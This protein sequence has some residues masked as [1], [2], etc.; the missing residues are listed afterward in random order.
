MDDKD[1]A[2]ARK[3]VELRHRYHQFIADVIKKSTDKQQTQR[4]KLQYLSRILSGGKRYKARADPDG[5]NDSNPNEILFRFF[6][7]FTG[8]NC[9][10]YWM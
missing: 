4:E 3:I 1:D 7:P 10:F 5:L 6:S 8:K 9:R 2:A